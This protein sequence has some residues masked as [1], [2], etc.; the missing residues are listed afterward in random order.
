MWIRL[1]L[2]LALLLPTAAMAATTSVH[3]EGTWTLRTST[4]AQMTKDY[5]CASEGKFSKDFTMVLARNILGQTSLILNWP[6]YAGNVGSVAP[7]RISVD[8]N[9]LRDVQATL[10]APDM[11]VVP[12]GWDDE[13]LNQ[14]ADA[15]QVTL[16]SAKMN[17]RYDIKDSSKAF[18]RLNSCTASLIDRLPGIQGMSSGLNATLSK[19]GLSHAKLI[20]VSDAKNGA[21]NFMIDGV[22]G[23]SVE[24]AGDKGDVTQR[25]LEYVDQLELL[26]RAK[27]SSELGA[28]TPVSG[29]E[30]ATAE[31][32]C[33]A[34]HT[35][36]ITALLFANDGGKP[37]V[38]Y[39]E[40][41]RDRLAQIRSLRD[42]IAKSLK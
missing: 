26:C 5:F 31:A 11:L 29:G 18:T 7:L 12:L 27:F 38:Y 17:V 32:K 25:M 28:P 13:A 14:L 16:A 42:M 37:R 22:F 9:S 40:G 34:A 6:G 24:L 3:Q 41:D 36:T 30:I 23:G 4:S 15:K 2:L 33:D 8:K 39:L 1:F 35:G 21:E 10:K 20:Q 19:S